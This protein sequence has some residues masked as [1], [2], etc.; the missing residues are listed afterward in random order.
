M[1]SEKDRFSSCIKERKLV[2]LD[3]T[4]FL[5][6]EYLIMKLGFYVLLNLLSQPVLNVELN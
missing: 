4:V 2:Y 1:Y 3:I 6:F 5:Y